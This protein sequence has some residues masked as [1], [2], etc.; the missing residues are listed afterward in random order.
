MDADQTAIEA[1]AL[2][3]AVLAAVEHGELDARSGQA[4]ALV[5]RMEGAIAGLEAQAAKPSGD[6]PE[7]HASPS[8]VH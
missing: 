8:L 6:R 1:A 3:R 2:L 4:K 5:R 7:K